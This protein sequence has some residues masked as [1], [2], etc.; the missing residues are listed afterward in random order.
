MK[1]VLT[2]NEIILA[3]THGTWRRI[4][5]LTRG[6]SKHLI[7]YKNPNPWDMDIEAAGAEMACSR[8]FNVY[9]A[10]TEFR[11]SADLG[12]DRE[13]KHTKHNDG[14]L[15][16]QKDDPDHYRFILVTGQIP[17]FHIRGWSLVRDGKKEKYWRNLQSPKTPAFF[18]PQ[19]DLLPIEMLLE[20]AKERNERS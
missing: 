6:G 20:E 4:R 14:C 8:V 2:E 18:V 13:V 9:W 12:E 19:K 5:A 16:M 11:A 17:V 7:Q 10:G 1:V 3:A 15:V